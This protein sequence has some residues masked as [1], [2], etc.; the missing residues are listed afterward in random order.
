MLELFS[1]KIK[2]CS[3]ISLKFIYFIIYSILY[4]LFYLDSNILFYISSILV[5]LPVM[6]SLYL[7]IVYSF[8][9][10]AAWMNQFPFLP[11]KI[12]CVT[13]KIWEGDLFIVRE[14]SKLEYEISKTLFSYVRKCMY[15]H[16]YQ[17]FKI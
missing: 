15:L 10:L 13:S 7:Y 9:C 3:R 14:P 8:L 12:P 5:S 4:F 1:N 16:D 11:K 2:I 17:E 6:H